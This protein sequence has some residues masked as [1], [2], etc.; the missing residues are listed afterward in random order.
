MTPAHITETGVLESSVK[1]AE[2]SKVVSAPLW[3]PPIPPVT[4]TLI[5]ARLAKYIVAATVVEPLPLV[6]R[7][8]PRSLKE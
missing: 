3:T 5:P 2:I 7:T 1:S 4:K 8:Y 6:A